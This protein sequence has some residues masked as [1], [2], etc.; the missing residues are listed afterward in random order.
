MASDRSPRLAVAARDDAEF[1]FST[2]DESIDLADSRS[3]R[4]PSPDGMSVCT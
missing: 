2:A 1:K 4:R 3:A